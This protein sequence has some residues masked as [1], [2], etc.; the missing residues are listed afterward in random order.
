[1]YAKL[2]LSTN[3]LRELATAQ[4]RLSHWIATYPNDLDMIDD[5]ANVCVAKTTARG[6]TPALPCASG[7][8]LT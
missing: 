5:V 8:P 2:R 3:W 1:M 4:D 6:V 7:G